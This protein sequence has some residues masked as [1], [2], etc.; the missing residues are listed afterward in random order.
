MSSIGAIVLLV[1][2]ISTAISV[3]TGQVLFELTGMPR[4]KAFFQALSCFTT[5]GFTTAEAEEIVNHPVRR[6]IAIV[7]MILGNVGI[8]AFMAA[9][10]ETAVAEGLQQLGQD[11]LVVVCLA[12]LAFIL[13]RA[14]PPFRALDRRLR[15]LLMKAFRFEPDPTEQVL[16][17]A[18]GFGVVRVVVRPDSLVAGKRLEATHLA[19]RR[20]VVLAIE[21]DGRNYPIPGRRARICQGDRLICY[22]SIADADRIMNG[23]RNL[24]P[25][26]WVRHTMEMPALSPADLQQ[27]APE[28]EPLRLP[29]GTEVDE[30]EALS[31]GY[32][33]MR[34]AL[35]R[36]ELE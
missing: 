7:L 35:Q 8:V 6:R 3:H 17:Y 1:V 33:I 21:R 5:T 30:E 12:T 15:I 22:G 31:H 10:V 29:D 19:A 18:D 13:I 26:A 32:T 4:H 20:L 36:E 28:F 23:E 2:A 34:K 11:A 9:V 27:P 16:R 14:L 25:E 24:D